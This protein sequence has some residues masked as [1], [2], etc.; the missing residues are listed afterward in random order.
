MPT[1]DALL[2]LLYLGIFCSIIA[3]LLYS[4]GLRKL[5][6]SSAVT[7]MNLVPVFGVFFSILFLNETMSAIQLLGGFIVIIGIIFSV[8][9]A[10]R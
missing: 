2:A 8:R 4:Y 1:G 7:L 10:N 3:F 6:S 9:E 5:A